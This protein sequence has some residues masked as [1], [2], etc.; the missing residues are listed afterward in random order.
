MAAA[1][2]GTLQWQ[3]VVLCKHLARQVLDIYLLQKQWRFA[4]KRQQDGRPMSISMHGD[5][6]ADSIVGCSALAAYLFPVPSPYLIFSTP[7]RWQVYSCDTCVVYL[8]QDKKTIGPDHPPEYAVI[9]RLVCHQYME[10]RDQGSCRPP[11]H[12]WHNKYSLAL[13]F[14]SKLLCFF[15]FFCSAESWDIRGLL[16]RVGKEKTVLK[17]MLPSKSANLYSWEQNLDVNTNINTEKF[18]ITRQ[19]KK[20][21]GTWEYKVTS[22]L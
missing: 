10:G 12:T 8:S 17:V 11:P 2:W 18:H 3:W 22:T 1:G 16:G 14:H 6:Q 21:S 4:G 19:I 15:F 5:K 20:K 9:F 7:E 13:S